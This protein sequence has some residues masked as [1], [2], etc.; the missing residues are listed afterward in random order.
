M[1]LLESTKHLLADRRDAGMTIREIVESSRGEVQ[2]EWL[3]K[4][5][6]GTVPNPTVK[7]VQQ[8]HDCLVK[9][10]QKTAA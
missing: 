8:L 6:S 4:F 7:R 5:L 2:Y 9:L 1:T 3:K 10:K